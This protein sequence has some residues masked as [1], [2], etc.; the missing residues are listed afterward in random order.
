MISTKSRA[1]L[2]TSFACTHFPPVVIVGAMFGDELVLCKKNKEGRLVVEDIE[3]DCD[4]NEMNLEAFIE[5]FK[6]SDGLDFAIIKAPTYF[7]I[8]RQKN[9]E[10]KIFATNSEDFVKIFA[11]PENIFGTFSEVNKN[12][13]NVFTLNSFKKNEI[14]EEVIELEG[15]ITDE[16]FDKILENDKSLKSIRLGCLKG[17]ILEFSR[18]PLKK[19][20]TGKL[21]EILNEMNKSKYSHIEI[22]GSVKIAGVRSKDEIIWFAEIGQLSE[23][24]GEYIR[25]VN[26]LLI[27]FTAEGD[28]EE[29]DE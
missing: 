2:L 4:E 21:S 13:K 28:I 9:R 18:F 3:M 10:V 14:N 15:I 22:Y 8:T 7:L 27:P 26:K 17:N 29:E 25:E 23:N 19:V 16:E 1:A 6:N 11:D 24:E 5:D 20:S 12:F